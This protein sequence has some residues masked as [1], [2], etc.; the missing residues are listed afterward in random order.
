MKDYPM[1]LS[2]FSWLLY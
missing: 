1:K 2:K